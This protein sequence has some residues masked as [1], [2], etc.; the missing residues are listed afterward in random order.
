MSH[1]PFLQR[2]S[3]V[4]TPA[5][6]DPYVTRLSEWITEW[7]GIEQFDIALLG[8]PLSKS[9][10]SFSGAHMHPTVFR[11]LFSSF[12][13]YNFEDDLELSSLRVRDLGDISMHITDIPQCHQNIEGTFQEL[14]KRLPTVIPCMV[15]GDHSIT[16]PAL[17]GIKSV[18]NQRIG[19][20]Q[21]DAHLDVRDTEYGGRSNGTPIRSLIENQVVKGEDLVTIGLRSFANSKEYR[22]YAEQ[23]GITLYTAKQVH[24]KGIKQVLDEAVN[25][26]KNK[27]DAVYV[28]FDIDVV[29][30]A[31]VP[32]VPAIGPG[33]LS[34]RDLFFCA[35]TLGRWEKTIA[36]DMVCVDP[37]Q[38][39]RD[40]TSRISLHVFLY[41]LTGILKRSIEK[42]DI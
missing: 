13:T 34:A 12:T 28:T 37:N 31:E 25:H 11:Q 33:G 2:P 7:D 39:T 29:D 38:D 3:F 10:I 15:G 22:T 30:Q 14:T 8:A 20:I 27:V 19:L 9:S 26:L 17:S 16:Y 36:M 5:K 1:I 18:R 40:R 35:E 24:D 42:I 23:K 41:F 32:G 6:G 21:F 4:F